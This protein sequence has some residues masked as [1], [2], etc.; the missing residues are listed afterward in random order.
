LGYTFKLEAHQS[1]HIELGQS[2]EK[3]DPGEISD[4]DIPPGYGLKAIFSFPCCCT[5]RN[6]QNGNAKNN[7]Y[8][9]KVL[10]RARE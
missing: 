2:K 8:I 9:C 5:P 7:S 3:D 10:K 4:A 6:I 1:F